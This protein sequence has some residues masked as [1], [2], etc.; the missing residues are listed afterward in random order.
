M[1]SCFTAAMT[2]IRYG[3]VRLL[4]GYTVHALMIIHVIIEFVNRLHARIAVGLRMARIMEFA[5]PHGASAEQPSLPKLWQSHMWGLRSFAVGGRQTP[6][7]MGFHWSL[8]PQVAFSALRPCVILSALSILMS[9]LMI[10]S[11]VSILM[12]VSMILS[13]TILRQ[14]CSSSGNVVLEPMSS[15]LLAGPEPQESFPLQPSLPLFPS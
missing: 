4:R 5:L 13:A 11:A 8:F 7:A 3:A 2:L 6:G 10:L 12:I 1:P 15:L 9:I 14:I